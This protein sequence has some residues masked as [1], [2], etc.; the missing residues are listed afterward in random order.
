[1]EKI[2]GCDDADDVIETHV[3]TWIKQSL[4]EAATTATTEDIAAMVL[5][6]VR[7]NIQEKES[8]MRIGQLPSDYLTL[9]R[10]QGWTLIK[11]QPKLAIKH[12][13]SVLK[14]AHL[15]ELCENGQ[16][17]EY[18]ELRK[19]FPR[20]IKH[21]KARAALAELLL[22]PSRSGKDAKSSDKTSTGSSTKSYS[23]GSHSG[24][25]A[26]TAKDSTSSTSKG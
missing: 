4:G 24:S 2:E 23:S 1:M 20:F 13:I 16:H 21:L 18:V 15:K 3:D 22:A 10:E 12:L 7:I 25:R 6:K 14:P 11:K 26:S 17:I 9:S 8:G 5:C 19:D